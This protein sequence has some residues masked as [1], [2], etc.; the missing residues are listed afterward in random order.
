MIVNYDKLYIDFKEAV[1]EC[2]YFCKEKEAENSI[3]DTSG[4]HVL[5]GM[6]VVP[7][8]LYVVNNK[9]ERIIKKIFSFMEQMA[10][11]ADVRVQEVLSVTI[12][13]QLLDMK[14]DDFQ[15]YKNYM[16]E[17]TLKYL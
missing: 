16:G 8:I 2:M 1:P 13:E 6:A 3:D 11:C 4:I 9:E 10:V 15:E 14:Y 17:N 12:L 7:Y 5:F